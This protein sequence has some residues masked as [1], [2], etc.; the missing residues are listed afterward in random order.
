[1]NV[2]SFLDN[3][4]NIHFISSIPFHLDRQNSTIPMDKTTTISIKGRMVISTKGRMVII[5]FLGQEKRKRK[6]KGQTDTMKSHSDMEKQGEQDVGRM[7]HTTS[8]SR[9]T[10]ERT[11]LTVMDKFMS[12][13]TMDAKFT[14]Q[15]KLNKCS[16][17]QYL[18]H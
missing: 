10:L 13:P 5:R 15:T 3:N 16:L 4:N 17:Y 9:G 6:M 8:H 12:L 7:K 18:F 2:N 1:M 14:V 11:L